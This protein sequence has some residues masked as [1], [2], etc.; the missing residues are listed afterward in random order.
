MVS[1]ATKIICHVRFN[2]VNQRTKFGDIQTKTDDI[3]I[4]SCI[5]T[6]IDLTHM[7]G[8]LSTFIKKALIMHLL[9]K[10]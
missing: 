8:Y 6:Q 4:K 7:Y 3:I 10:K 2:I 1:I 5:F 9:K